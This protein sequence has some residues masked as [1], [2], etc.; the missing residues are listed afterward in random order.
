MPRQPRIPDQSDQRFTLRLNGLFESYRGEDGKPC[1]LRHVAA[2]TGI[3]ASYLSN[4]RRGRTTRPGADTLGALARFFGVE[5][6]YFMSAEI[7]A[8]VLG[9]PLTEDDA[10]RQAL[11]NP[12]V[13]EIALRTGQ[14]GLEEWTHMLAIL[15]HQVALQRLTEERVRREG[16]L[17]P[18]V[19]TR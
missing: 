15:E 9:V 8:A 14:F 6:S 4:L 7:D 16:D 3:S 18:G 19:S 2:R 5:M 1:S 13:R 11:E 10:L 17:P 12:L